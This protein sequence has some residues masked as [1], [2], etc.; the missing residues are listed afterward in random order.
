ML[1]DPVNLTDRS[2]LVVRALVE[3]GFMVD[4]AAGEIWLQ[5]LRDTDHGEYVYGLQTVVAGVAVRVAMAGV[6]LA[7]A[8]KGA[9]TSFIESLFA[10][11]PGDAA[12]E[13]MRRV[14]PLC[15]ENIDCSE[16]AED[17]R[18]S[19]GHGQILRM[20]S[21]SG[22]DLQLE[23][24][25]QV[26]GGFKYHDVYTDGRFVYDPRYSENPV[27]LQEWQ[28]RMRELNPDAEFGPAP[29]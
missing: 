2:G 3:L 8:A 11:S 15:G 26:Q 25:G 6:S 28:N 14:S 22:R 21:G 1:A 18:D 4:E 12:T 5:N 17:I 7:N 29:P 10:P 19:A 13:A 24:F 9:V 27:R 20:R 16:I 23:E